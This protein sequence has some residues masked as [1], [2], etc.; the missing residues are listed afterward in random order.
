MNLTLILTHLQDWHAWELL[1]F[2][3]LG[4]FGVCSMSLEPFSKSPS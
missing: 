2:V 4:I 3:I 1:P